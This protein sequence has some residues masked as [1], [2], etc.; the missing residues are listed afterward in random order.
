MTASFNEVSGD[1]Q[2]PLQPIFIRVIELLPPDIKNSLKVELGR[3]ADGVVFSTDD[4]NR[5]IKVGAFRPHPSQTADFAW[6]NLARTLDFL[7]K[8]P[9]EAYARVF[10]YQSLGS[11]DNGSP[12]FYVMERLQKLS[13]DEFK[14]YHSI[15]SH[16]DRNLKKDLSKNKI[17]QI[18]SE[19]N[20]GLDFNLSEIM[21]FCERL[22]KSKIMHRDLHPRNVL[23]T[24]NGQFKLIDFERCDIKSYE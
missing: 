14:V 22:K 8:S 9:S 2:K 24:L 15:L 5:A 11:L 16:E 1:A 4:P 7:I 18:L 23:K 6:R 19:L 3:G 20:R 12:Y 10:A 21:L 13:D 17:Y